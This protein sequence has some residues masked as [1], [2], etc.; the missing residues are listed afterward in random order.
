[1]GNANSYAGATI[2][3]VLAALVPFS[4]FALLVGE[5]LERYRRKTRHHKGA[6][7]GAFGAAAGTNLDGPSNASQPSR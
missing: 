2:A 7:R 4:V 6:R 1:M 5:R 3:F